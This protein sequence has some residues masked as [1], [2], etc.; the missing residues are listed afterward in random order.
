MEKATFETD[1]DT[2]SYYVTCYKGPAI[3]FQYLKSIFKNGKSNVGIW[4][5]IVWGLKGLM[6]FLEKEGCINLD[7]YINQVLEGLKPPFYNQCIKEKSS[8][9]WMDD[10]ACYHTSKM[11]TVYCRFVKLICI[12][13]P[14]QSPDLNPIKNLWR[15]IKIQVNAQRHW[16]HLL[17]LMKEVIKK[18]WEKLT[19]EDFCACIE[20]M[21]KQCKLVIEA[22]G[23][24]IKYWPIYLIE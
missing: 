1:L 2:L 15:I 24:S 23:G 17:E 20:S 10:G 5:V 14:A 13:W 18:E 22:R 19:E 4:R 3:E 9:I 11:T 8:M 6:H 12:I 21:L 7:I 16:I